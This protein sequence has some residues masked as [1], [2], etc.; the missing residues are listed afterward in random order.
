MRIREIFA[1]DIMPIRFLHVDELSDVVVLAGPNGVGKTRFVNWL[2]GFIQSLP[3]N[4]S[5]WIQIEATSVEEREQWGTA[6]L[7]TRKPDDLAKLRPVLQRRRQ[8]GQY[9]SSL[10]HFESNRAITQI[11]PYAFTWDAFDSTRS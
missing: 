2:I 7:D 8:R 6:V 4:E 1:K 3:S 11:K 9:T 10:L 5:Q